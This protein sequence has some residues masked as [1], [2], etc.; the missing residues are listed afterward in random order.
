MITYNDIYDAARKERYSDQLQNL[1]KDFIKEVASYLREKK[2]LS[3]R[4]DNP[5]SESIIKT[6]KQ[7]EN[8]STLFRELI[9][10]RRKKILN[11]VLISPETGVSKNE[12]DN[13]LSF[14]KVL[15]DDLTMCLEISEKK[16]NELFKEYIESSGKN[17][18]I[19]FIEDVDGFVDLD[20]NILGPFSKGET[21]NV[22]KEISKILIGGGKAKILS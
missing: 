6:K 5:F 22:P 11:L 9:L 16:F 21:A 1:P 2:D 3:L 8:A 10:R 7:F 15:F 13:L 18:S 12:T 20:G 17:Q 19:C 4:E 14:E